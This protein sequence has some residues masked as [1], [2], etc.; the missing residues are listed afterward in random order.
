MLVSIPGDSRGAGHAPGVQRAVVCAC[1]CTRRQGLERRLTRKACGQVGKELG[2]GTY[3]LVSYFAAKTL[4]SVPFE[5]LVAMI[6][7][8]IIYNMIGFQ[9]TAAKF[10]LFMVTLVLVNLTSDMVGFIC[11]VVT[12]ARASRAC[13]PQAAR[14]PV[15]HPGVC[16][17]R[18]IKRPRPL[19]ARVHTFAVQGARLGMLCR[20]LVSEAPRAVRSSPR[21]CRAGC[22]HRP[23]PHL[24]GHLLLLR[25]LGLHRAAGAVLLR[26]AAQGAPR[27]GRPCGQA[28]RVCTR[29]SFVCSGAPASRCGHLLQPASASAAVAVSSS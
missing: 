26:L 22:V 25:V 16:P 20:A 28:G 29:C 5:T 7:S 6:F 9:A 2:A 18:C 19:S 24:C 4:V 23:H 14:A 11:G 12:K 21:V 27:G 15:A 3:R 10:F 17:L 13:A 8:V 1:A